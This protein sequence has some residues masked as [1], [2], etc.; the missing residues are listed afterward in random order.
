MPQNAIPGWY[1]NPQNPDQQRWWD[2]QAW[3][4]HWR[5]TPSAD[6]PPATLGA[7]PAPSAAA[8]QTNWWSRRSTFGKT[9]TVLVASFFLIAFL[10]SLQP[11][12][13][14]Q[15]V[16]A[17]N[18]QES[19]TPRVKTAP[20][21]NPT[22][23]ST[24]S[25]IPSPTPSSVPTMPSP[26]PTEPASQAPQTATPATPSEVATATAPDKIPSR[27]ILSD[28]PSAEIV[29]FRDVEEALAQQV[30]D[31]LDGQAWWPFVSEVAVDEDLFISDVRLRLDV[32]MHPDVVPTAVAMCQAV[33]ASL[34]ETDE[35]IAVYVQPTSPSAGGQ[36]IDGSDEPWKLGHSTL[37]RGSNSSGPTCD[38][39]DP[40]RSET[41]RTEQF[42]AEER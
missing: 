19:P 31:A 11:E 14:E 23:S 7:P 38:P 18:V 6:A 26:T 33:V 37:I 3:T 29:A 28:D 30:I 40:S 5:Q 9:V 10:G 1:T 35:S 4:E 41:E 42:I 13:D 27:L 15:P 34:P 16:S 20:L 22:P 36:E 25:P 32:L 24:P 17:S 8:T 12:V 21:A 39:R 2:G